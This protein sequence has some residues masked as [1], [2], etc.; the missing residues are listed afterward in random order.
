[1]WALGN[2]SGDSPALRDMVITA[3]A[4]PPVLD[5]IQPLMGS[6]AD[7]VYLRNAAWTLSNFCR[8][9]PFVDHTKVS[10]VKTASFYE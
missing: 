4:V 8:G 2:I 7:I 3:G 10:K 6:R 1:M 5:H 9:K